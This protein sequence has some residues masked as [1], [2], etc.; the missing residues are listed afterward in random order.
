LWGGDNMRKDKELKEMFNLA[1]IELDIQNVYNNQE[2]LLNL[3]RLIDNK[4]S[5]N[6]I[7]NINGKVEKVIIIRG[8][9]VTLS[10]LRI[11][12]NLK[13][14]SSKLAEKQ[15]D[16]SILMSALTI[17]FNIIV[18]TFISKSDASYLNIIFAAIVSIVFIYTMAFF[19]TRIKASGLEIN[20]HSTKF[21]SVI[22]E[23]LDKI[24]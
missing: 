22:I 23:I 12:C 18:T 15:M 2:T 7:K 17:I 1:N 5:D 19:I 21:Y 20:S 6:T 11:I 14:Q 10:T 24:E 4:L 9:K 13:L 8:Q 3:V 16:F